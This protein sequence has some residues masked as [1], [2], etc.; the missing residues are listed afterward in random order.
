MKDD[1]S[2]DEHMV[3]ADNGY[4]E[5]N[6]EKELFYAKEKECMICKYSIMIIM[7]WSF[8]F[9]WAKVLYNS[10][11]NKHEKDKNKLGQIGY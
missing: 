6:L 5:L 11:N 10:N 1:F 9:T 2:I 3:Q 7:I 4:H 8:L